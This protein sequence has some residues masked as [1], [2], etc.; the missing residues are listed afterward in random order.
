MQYR[1]KNPFST[2]PPTSAPHFQQ[3][4]NFEKTAD[5]TPDF[6]V[7]VVGA[8]I[9]GSVTARKLALRGYN[10]ALLERGQTPGEK[11]LS[12]GIFY[13]RVMEE[14]FPDFLNNAP[15]ERMITRNVISFLNQNS[16]F[17]LDYWD[18]RLASPV[19]AVSVLRAKLDP[20]LAE[21]AEEAGVILMPGVRVEHFLHTEN[22][23]I[24]GIVAG[25]EQLTAHIV[26]AADG[27][28]SYLAQEIGIR[29]KQPNKNLALGVK[30]VFKL[31]PEKITERFNLDRAHPS[32]TSNIAQSDDGNSN[33]PT[34]TDNRKIADGT[35]F[36]LV[37]DATMGVAGGGFLYTNIDTISVGVVLRL[38]DLQEKNLN[39]LEIHD[40]LI[41]HPVIASYLKD[42]QPIE[43]GCH[44]T[45]ENGTEMTQQAVSAA[46]LMIIGDAA[47]YTLNNGFTIRGMDLAAQSA[48]CAAKTAHQ[49]LCE[50]DFSASSMLRYRDEIASSWLGADL[51]NAHRL[52]EFLENPRIFE[53]YGQVI[54]DTF[55]GIYNI[56]LSARKK[57]R[58]IALAALKNAG[59]KIPTVIRD[60]LNAIR[61]L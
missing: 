35:A 10:V 29:P 18:N 14:I 41:N 55:Y 22:G 44:L 25:D 53:K 45:I 48:I 30:S 42:A 2:Q 7:I 3:P 31:S 34:A 4:A 47:G 50:K 13:T 59:I 39:S 52:P 20:W 61:T 38:D 1:W 57:V 21:Q 33:T 15:V 27:V 56:D 26:I 40:H 43:Y 51:K 12:G 17:N 16:H 5:F 24:C 36:A 23:E 28:N 46:G 49:A 11:N 9:A 19:N 60:M 32:T 58:R 54:A 37:G 8:G 6:D